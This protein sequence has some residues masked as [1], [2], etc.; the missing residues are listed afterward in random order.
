MKTNITEL[1]FLLDRSGSMGGLEKDTIGGFNAMLKTQQA[2]AG[3]A[4]LTT[5]LFDNEYTLIHDRLDLN[6][7]RPITG[8]DYFVRGSTALLD[9]IGRSIM[10]V[11][12]VMKACDLPHRPDKVLFVIITDGMENSS[13]RFTRAQIAELVRQRQQM[14]WEFIFL[15]ANMDAI[16][17]AESYGINKNRAETFI[18]DAQGIGMNFESVSRVASE[19]RANR[20]I[21]ADWS[22]SIRE[23][24]HKKG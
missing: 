3:L 2:Q 19:V 15:G 6:A 9:A 21:S 8:E 20:P 13:H 11:D 7:V 23:H 12:S 18:S 24:S 1:V 22:R 16:T 17:V 4:R 5:V 14:G 10:K